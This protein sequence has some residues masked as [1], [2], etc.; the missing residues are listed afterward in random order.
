MN[1]AEY[2]SK[3]IQDLKDQGNVLST[4]AWQA[5]LACLG[6]A[7]VFGAR[8]EYCTP[9][10]RRSR[11]SDEHPTIKSNCK[12][13]NGSGSAGCKGCKWYPQEK[14]TRFFDCRGFTY[15]ILKQVYGW[16]LMG[17]G[18]TSQWN[19]ESNWK[20]KGEISTMP[21]DTLCCLF[22]KKGAK[23]EHTG[24]GLNDQ[25]VECSAGVQ[26]YEH[27]KK[28]W[29]HWAVPA[30]VEGVEPMPDTKPTIRRGDKGPYVTLA[31]TELI[32]RGYDLGKWGADGD[33]GAQTE[34]AVKAFQRA[35]GL[36]EDGIIGPATWAKLES[37]EPVVKYRVIIPHLTEKQAEGLIAQYPEAWKEGE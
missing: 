35:N 33:F 13:Y 22:V 30:C 23:M 31:Q 28:K 36:A 10:N 20:A 27:R 7:Y 6:W 3:L 18:A 5:A 29:T 25:T 4:V 8:G 9:S 32:N 2:V 34:K 26:Y 1:S 17:A 24:F 16:E 19:R 37:T 14:L 21:R 15:W 12:N 11:Y